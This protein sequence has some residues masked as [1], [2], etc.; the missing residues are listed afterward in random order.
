MNDSF[1]ECFAYQSALKTRDQ[2]RLQRKQGSI[3]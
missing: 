2:Q 1:N 3:V